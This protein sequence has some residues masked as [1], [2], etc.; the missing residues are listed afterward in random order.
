ML[1]FRR[2]RVARL[3]SYAD[4]RCAVLASGQ[5]TRAIDVTSG[6]PFIKPS[7]DARTTPGAEKGT[8]PVPTLRGAWTGFRGRK[9]NALFCAVDALGYLLVVQVSGDPM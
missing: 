4:R 8:T 9:R 3:H 6:H 5:A 7:Y 1:E 2:L